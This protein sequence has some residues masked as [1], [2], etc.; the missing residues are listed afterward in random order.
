MYRAALLRDLRG[1]R[2]RLRG[3]PEWN[4]CGRRLR[5]EKKK[6]AFAAG[7]AAL[8]DC[9]NRKGLGRFRQE[10]L[11]D[12]GILRRAGR[13]QIRVEDHRHIAQERAPALCNRDACVVPSHQAIV[14]ERL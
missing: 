13:P 7:E 5:L 6:A 4:A 3:T 1:A 11:D 8:R 10:K 12:F 14:R 2:E 9:L